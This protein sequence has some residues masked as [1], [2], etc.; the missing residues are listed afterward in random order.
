MHCEWKQKPVWLMATEVAAAAITRVH[1]D[2]GKW[3][4]EVA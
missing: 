1:A 2:G 4:D 3:Q